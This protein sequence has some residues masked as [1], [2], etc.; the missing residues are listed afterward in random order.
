MS[1]IPR[2]DLPYTTMSAA[3]FRKLGL[4]REINRKILHPLGLALH[5]CV[6]PDT[7]EEYFGQVRDY[8]ASAPE[9]VA[10]PDEALDSDAVRDSTDALDFARAERAG[11]R[12]ALYG[13]VVQPIPER[14]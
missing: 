12:A 3:E 9:G 14:K 6:D 8:R 4:L 13:W 11:K 10:F 2:L 5:T 1:G 7:G